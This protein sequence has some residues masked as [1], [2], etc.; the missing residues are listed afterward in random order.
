MRIPNK[1][2]MGANGREYRRWRLQS[3]T[4]GI[5]ELFKLELSGAW[6]PPESSCAK[7][8][9]TIKVPAT[10][11]EEGWSCTVVGSENDIMIRSFSNNHIDALI[12]DGEGEEKWIFIGQYGWPDDSS[13]WRTW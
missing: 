12:G 13:K 3:P 11:V 4:I 8:R 9:V 5:N 7:A 1:T 6:E 2:L 10:V